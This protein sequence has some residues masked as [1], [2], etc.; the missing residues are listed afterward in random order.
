MLTKKFFLLVALFLSYATA[1]PYN[2]YDDSN[3]A[4]LVSSDSA[5]VI[6]DS[7]IVVFKKHVDKEQVKY[8]HSCIHNYITEEKRSLSKRGL[9]EDLIS[10]INHTFDFKNFQG[11]SGK[12]SNEILEKIRRSD[13]V[14]VLSNNNPKF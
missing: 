11:Y 12:F 14:N 6:P 3:I 5:Q 9:L 2:T 1:A 13:E 8:H 4:P 10:G 7:Y